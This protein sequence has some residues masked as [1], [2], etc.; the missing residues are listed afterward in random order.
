VTNSEEKGIGGGKERKN[1]KKQLNKY[2]DPTL[3]NCLFEL[4]SQ[5]AQIQIRKST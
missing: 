2:L 4:T 1:T 3:Q 5:T